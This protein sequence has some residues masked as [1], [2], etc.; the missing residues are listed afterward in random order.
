MAI[1]R[2][3]KKAG[4]S[5]RIPFYLAGNVRH[6]VFQSSHTWRA[7]IVNEDTHD[8]VAVVFN[9]LKVPEPQDPRIGDPVDSLFDR[10]TVGGG[11]PSNGSATVVEASI[12]EI[13]TQPG[14]STKGYVEITPIMPTVRGSKRSRNRPKK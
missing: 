11:D 8:L 4:E 12:V 5:L 2:K 7:K 14:P 6:R 13:R 1:G 9:P 3:G 10:V